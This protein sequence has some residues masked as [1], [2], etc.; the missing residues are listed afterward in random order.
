MSFVW[1]G[2]LNCSSLSYLYF[3]L[4]QMTLVAIFSQT[5]FFDYFAVKVQLLQ[6]LSQLGHIFSQAYKLARGRVWPLISILCIFSAFVSAF[7]VR[8]V[9]VH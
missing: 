6:T 9:V 7:L 4:L 8:P 2:I 5:G 3:S 1:N